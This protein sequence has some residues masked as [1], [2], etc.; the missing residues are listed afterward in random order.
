[1]VVTLWQY[2]DTPIMTMYHIIKYLDRSTR[3]I[4]LQHSHSTP[5][6]LC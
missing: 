1:M 6:L 5:H 4:V 2:L 3:L